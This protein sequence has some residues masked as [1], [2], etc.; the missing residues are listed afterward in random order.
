M[1]PR[2]TASQF[3]DPN[4]VVRPNDFTDFPTYFV[5]KVRACCH[6]G[7]DG[8]QALV[9]A[10]SRLRDREHSPP[11]AVHSL[12][13]L[14]KLNDN[15]KNKAL[16]D[17]WVTVA[18]RLC[19]S[20]TVTTSRNCS[21]RS[22]TSCFSALSPSRR[23]LRRTACARSFILLTPCAVWEQLDRYLRYDRVFPSYQNLITQ[24]CLKV[25]RECRMPF[26]S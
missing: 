3:C 1:C 21:W 5:G 10:L 12:V 23:V 13:Q 19:S 14:L 26:V 16:A 22:A 4:E 8:A 7:R 17:L 25:W 20:R 2:L 9:H 6:S 18:T 15:S 11:E 24:A